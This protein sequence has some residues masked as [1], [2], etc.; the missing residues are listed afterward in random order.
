[1]EGVSVRKNVTRLTAA[2]MAVMLILPLYVLTAAAYYNRGQIV[3]SCGTGSVTLEA[4]QKTYVS[5]SV[6]PGEDNHPPGCGMPECPDSCDLGC[7]DENGNCVCAGTEYQTYYT[8]VSVTSSNSAVA[9]GSYWDGTLVITGI[10]PGEATITLTGTLAEWTS[11][12]ASV[13]VSVSAAPPVDPTP[14]P[15]PPQPPEQTPEP[16]PGKVKEPE[17]DK[18]KSEA[19]DEENKENSNKGNL[20]QTQNPSQSGEIKSSETE[21]LSETTSNPITS[22]KNTADANRIQKSGEI[23]DA[24][25][26]G[27]ENDETVT[28]AVPD[29]APEKEW[30]VYSLGD[31]EQGKEE[32]QK[33]KPDPLKAMAAGS[34]VFLFLCGVLGEYVVYR[35]RI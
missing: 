16:L 7:M 35:R 27:A 18:E 14:D 9:V 13:N 32:K 24:I 22:E 20:K 4:A 19:K 30:T 1:M 2:I 34:G 31:E 10:S 33:E 17:K 3:V 11:G 6:S 21:Q 23:L 12:A 8:D 15:E 26:T 28:A 29:L 25:D 5:V